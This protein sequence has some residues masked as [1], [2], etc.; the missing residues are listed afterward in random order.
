MTAL[1]TMA[2]TARPPGIGDARVPCPLCGGLIHPVAGR[3]KHCKEDLSSF[4][5]G[6]PQ[7]AAT[8]PALNGQPISAPA[9]STLHT[10]GPTNGFAPPA[11]N[12]VNG[13]AGTNGHAPAA[14]PIAIGSTREASQPILPPRQTGS[15][16]AKDTESRS[17]W[18]SWPMIVI[19]LAVLAIVGAVVIMVLPQET[20]KSGKKI[21]APP[22]AP[23]RMD[24][25]PTHPKS[26]QL[27]PPPNGNDPWAQ[28]DP[29]PSLPRPQLT[30]SQPDPNDPNDIYGALG[31]GGPTM[32]GGGAVLMAAMGKMCTKLK[33]CG[34]TDPTM[35]TVCE[36]FTAMQRAM[37]AAP[38]NCAA[39]QK[40]LQAIDNISCTDD[41]VNAVTAVYTIQDCSTAITDC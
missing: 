23:E 22:P 15:W 37:P 6:R 7:A 14:A 12:V 27:T 16:R 24:V 11:I 21:G 8:L 13:H 35:Q 39:A 30:P 31:G 3:C 4:R 9:P 25:D 29:D 32:S 19:G 18:R 28:P 36:Q 33:T 10:P 20:K 17:M 40:C 5:A 41:A 38:S 2:A 34:N 1:M 26:S